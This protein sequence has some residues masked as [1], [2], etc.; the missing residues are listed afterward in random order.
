MIQ[1]LFYKLPV[2]LLVRATCNTIKQF[3]FCDFRNTAV[4]PSY[5]F[6]VLSYTFILS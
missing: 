6:D 5:F 3:Y 2:F 4:L 1:E